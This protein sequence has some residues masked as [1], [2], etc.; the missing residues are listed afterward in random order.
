MQVQVT[1]PV[2]AVRIAE[3]LPNVRQVTLHGASLH[4]LAGVGAEPGLRAGL[5]RAGH[6]VDAIEPVRLSMDDVFA[7]LVERHTARRERAA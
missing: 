6:V 1:R 3:A 7:A 5:E 4:V 2:Q